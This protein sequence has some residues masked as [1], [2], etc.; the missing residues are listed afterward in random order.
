MST[1]ACAHT[2]KHICM[3]VFLSQV[4]KLFKIKSVFNSII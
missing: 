4:N 2:H 1:S 3:C